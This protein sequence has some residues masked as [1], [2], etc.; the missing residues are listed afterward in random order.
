MD[1]SAFQNKRICV[2]IS[3]G[4]DSTVLLHYLKSKQNEYGYQ[5]CA[6][7]CEH[8]IRG[9]SS[10]ADTRF[11]KSICQEWEIPLECFS[12]DCLKRAKEEKVS[13]ETAARNFRYECFFSLLAGGRCEFIAL[14]H[15][16]NDEAETVL[17]RLARGA[18]L[19]GV[20]A[21]KEIEGQFLRPLLKWSKVDVL[22]YAKEQGLS[23]CEDETNSQTDATRNKLRLNVLPALEESVSGAIKNL[24]KFAIR[25]EED[26]KLLYE[27]SAP[28]I[29]KVEKTSRADSG[30]RLRFSQQKPLFTRACLSILKT[31]NLV[32][33]YTSMHLDDVYTLQEKETGASVTLPQNI[34]A[35][36]GYG[37]IIFYQNLGEE[38]VAW[39]TEIPFQIG[40][41][42]WGRY[43]IIVQ[44]NE[45]DSAKN[46]LRIDGDKIPKDAV[47]RLKRQGDR[48]EKFSGGSKS[49]KKYLIDKKIE[50]EVREELPIL[51]TDD[52][53]VYAV[54][55]VEISKKIKIT[56]D[57]KRTLYISIQSKN[58]GEKQ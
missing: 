41:Y 23:F 11:V 44:S 29:E 50:K 45:I 37:E 22:A 33:D 28:L 6:V 58:E 2:A 3:G 18:S 39:Q 17:F 38:S 27:L 42:V 4:A 35:K 21:M 20:S 49:L 25:A 13:V 14:A 53:E 43:E 40:K 46:V 47:I 54:L 19:T 8:G 10:L 16:E 34:I 30:Y 57:T 32:K 9:E 12:E 48:F 56:A 51:A 15:H 24:A 7:N 5:L 55:G 31:L 52:G 36:K 1:L 26:D